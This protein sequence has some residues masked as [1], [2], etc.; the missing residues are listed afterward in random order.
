MSDKVFLP[1]ILGTVR[2][3]RRSERVSDFLLS[4]IE[5]RDD[6]ETQLFDVRDFKF[7]GNGYG[8]DIKDEF[9]EY[10]DAVIKADGLIIVA[11][12]YN[13]GYPGTLKSVLDVLYPE[14][15]HKV[16][17]IVGVS[18]G[19]WGGTRVVENLI[20]VLHGMTLVV[21]PAL[22]IPN[23]RK[24][25]EEGIEVGDEMTVKMTERFFDELVWMAKMLK[26]GR[27]NL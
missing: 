24:K 18:G 15:K 14:Y 9:P 2:E 25:V 8:Q 13:H 20:P 19:P 21:G 3:G 23:M 27:K 7:P 11:P 6:I 17:G 26:W 22:N 10:R 12:E 5:K 4:E 1:L 16:A